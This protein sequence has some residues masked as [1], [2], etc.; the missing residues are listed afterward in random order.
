MS[1]P[2]QH[3]PRWNEILD[4]GY[5]FKGNQSE[6]EIL[7]VVETADT[8]MSLAGLIKMEDRSTG[9]K[10]TPLK[11]ITN[12]FTCLTPKTMVT[13]VKP[14]LLA[15]RSLA[16][17]G[18]FSDH[19]IY[20]ELTSFKRS[21]ESSLGDSLPRPR[22]RPPR[23][24]KSIHDRPSSEDEEDREYALGI[25]RANTI[26]NPKLRRREKNR[27]AAQR[28]RARKSGMMDALQRDNNELLR[29]IKE[30]EHQNQELYSLIRDLQ[31]AKN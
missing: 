24:S 27:L 14:R 1:L 25:E 15:P 18:S 5:V 9:F 20:Q 31:S 16:P 19:G 8:L 26:A 23:H 17:S 2:S 10:R 21:P 6:S 7:D 4:S 22:G 11:C 3:S 12:Q 29:R 28:S 13:P 30:L